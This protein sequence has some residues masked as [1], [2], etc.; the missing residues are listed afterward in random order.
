MLKLKFKK[1]HATVVDNVNPTIIIDF[2]YQTAVISREDVSELQKS[3]DDPK[4]QCSDLLDLLRA[5]ENPQ[6]FVLLYAAVK[7]ESHLPWLIERIDKFTDQSLIDLLQQMY[8]SEPTGQRVFQQGK[9]LC[10]IVTF[11][12][13]LILY[14]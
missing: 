7:A 4:Q 8:I 11:N 9:C 2:L 12:S 1:L 10:C 6:A 13:R 5:S 14:T 3:K